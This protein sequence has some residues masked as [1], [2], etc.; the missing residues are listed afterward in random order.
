M[1]LNG[2]VMSNYHT[3][4]NFIT[5]L[6]T[7]VQLPLSTETCCRFLCG[8]SIPIFTR[9]KVRQMPGFSL[10]EQLPYAQIRGKVEVLKQVN[11]WQI[12]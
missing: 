2:Q 6:S 12:V 9:N 4:S 10:C 3:C 7:K 8:M 11:N 5:Q 1:M